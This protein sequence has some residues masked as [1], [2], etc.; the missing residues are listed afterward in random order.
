MREV[1]LITLHQK[2]I[3]FL[4]RAKIYG[5]GCFFSSL[6]G[7]AGGGAMSGLSLSLYSTTAES[8]VTSVQELEKLDVEKFGITKAQD[9]FKK[10]TE[11]LL[12]NFSR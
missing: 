6:V 8:K 2:K 10:R 4:K 12:K 3:F 9:L 7:G 11:N 5:L 1:Y